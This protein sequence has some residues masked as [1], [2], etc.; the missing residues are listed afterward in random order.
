MNRKSYWDQNAMKYKSEQ[1][2]DAR[3]YSK[4]DLLEAKEIFHNLDKNEKYYLTPNA[5]YDEYQN[6][7]F[8]PKYLGEYPPIIKEFK[9]LENLAE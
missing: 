9:N 6:V 7:V 1:V 4:K 2:R 8:R 3:N 5:M